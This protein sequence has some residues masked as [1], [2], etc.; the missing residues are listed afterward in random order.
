MKMLS[1]MWR[2]LRQLSIRCDYG[3]TVT[4]MLRDR[5]VCGIISHRIQQKLLTGGSTLTF[6]SAFPIG[7]TIESV[8]RETL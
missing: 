2:A 7:R 8:R 4:K 5:L 1:T 6:T 3:N